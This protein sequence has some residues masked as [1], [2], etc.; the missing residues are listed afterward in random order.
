[1]D[2]TKIDGVK[3]AGEDS[4]NYREYWKIRNKET[5]KWSLCCN[6][7]DNGLNNKPTFYICSRD[8]EPSH[9]IT[10]PVSIPT[11]PKEIQ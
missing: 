9:E 11:E 4:G 8:G 3:Y 6:Q 10:R 7:W 2:K 1:M 5:G